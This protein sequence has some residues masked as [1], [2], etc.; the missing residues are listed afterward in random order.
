MCTCSN[1]NFFFAKPHCQMRSASKGRPGRG[2]A[3]SQIYSGQTSQKTGQQTDE[4]WGVRIREDLLQREAI[5]SVSSAMSTLGL[6]RST[7][8]ERIQCPSASVADVMQLLRMIG[9]GFTPSICKLCALSAPL[10]DP[11]LGAGPQGQAGILRAQ[12]QQILL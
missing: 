10:P 1:N 5:S 7:G 4:G 8:F 9:S 3:T 6:C 11:D 12:Q 2:S